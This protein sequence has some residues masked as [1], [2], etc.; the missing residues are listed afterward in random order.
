VLRIVQEA[1]SN[2]RKHASARNVDLRVQQTPQWRFE[3][4]DDGAGFDAAADAGESHVG[5]RI[6]RERAARIGAHVEVDSA[7]G[8]GTRVVITVPSPM[9]AARENEDEHAAAAA[10]R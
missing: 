1:L 6:M 4:A 7:P 3:V 9:D 5:L 8:A 2:V 10:S